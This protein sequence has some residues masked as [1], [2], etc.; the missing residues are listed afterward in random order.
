M[1]RFTRYS[2]DCMRK[3]IFSFVTCTKNDLQIL[4]G[5]IIINDYDWNAS[6]Y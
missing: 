2:N 1:V 4:L 6:V 5:G 3:D